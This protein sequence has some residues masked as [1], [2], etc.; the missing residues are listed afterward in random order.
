MTFFFLKS[1]IIKR[2][3]LCSHKHVIR[4]ST[5]A[6]SK[7]FWEVARQ[8]VVYTLPVDLDMGGNIEPEKN[9]SLWF[10]IHTLITLLINHK[11]TE[12][13]CRTSA[14]K[15]AVLLFTWHLWHLIFRMWSNILEMRQKKK[16]CSKMYHTMCMN[17]LHTVTNKMCNQS[18]EHEISSL[19]IHIIRSAD[20]M[21]LCPGNEIQL[22]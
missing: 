2:P 10:S 16:V 9:G 1:A 21:L 19:K 17:K 8:V 6:G 7:G 4:C 13:C 3:N 5:N 22:K 15:S 12:Q 18:L 11:C 14:I 20:K